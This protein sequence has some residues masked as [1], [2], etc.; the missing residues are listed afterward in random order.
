MTKGSRGGEGEEEEG[1]EEGEAEG[2]RK[3]SLVQVTIVKPYP[4]N[5]LD[6]FPYM[7]KLPHLSVHVYLYHISHL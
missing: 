1:E 5:S 7:L 6:K 3:K 2:R 4:I